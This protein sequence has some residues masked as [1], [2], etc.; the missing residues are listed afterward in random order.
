VAYRTL[1]AFPIVGAT[2][3]TERGERWDHGEVLTSVGEEGSDPDFE[4]DG[5][6]R[7]WWPARSPCDGDDSVDLRRWDEVP[8]ARLGVAELLVVILC[9]GD[10]YVRRIERRCRRLGQAD[11]SGGAVQGSWR[12]GAA[13][14]RRRELGHV[15]TRARLK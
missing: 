5:G 2:S 9:S 7:P 4:E 3:K 14:G 6:G 1:W 15:R 12:G 13:Q 8:G 11:A 10:A